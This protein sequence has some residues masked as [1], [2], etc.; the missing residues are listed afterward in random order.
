[1]TG[2]DKEPSDIVG[3]A[4]AAIAEGGLPQLAFGKHASDAL[5]RLIGA[6]TDVPAAYLERF[7]ARIRADTDAQVA[8]TKAVAECGIAETLAA[9]PTLA[10]R[11]AQ[12]WFAGTLRKQLNKDAVAA[13]SARILLEAPLPRDS[14]PPSEEFLDAFTDAAGTA[15]SDE[16]RE[17]FARVLT[18]ELRRPGS[19]SRATLAALTTI[20]ARQAQAFDR[21]LP[22]IDPNAGLLIIDSGFG[23]SVMETGLLFD[24]GLIRDETMFQWLDDED[25]NSIAVLHR[26]HIITISGM[27]KSMMGP[28]IYGGHHLTTTGQELLTALDGGPALEPEQLDVIARGL[29]RELLKNQPTAEVHVGPY[30][31]DGRKV[32]PG[33]LRRLHPVP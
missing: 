24:A 9:D 23:L 22:F 29:T 27:G 16:I 12:G 19:F 6:A 32:V 2:S 17:A 7:S 30:T 20:D 15:T 3:K 10:T 33:T 13:R 5:G 28:P 31:V 21:A 14:L 4:L 8:M 1:M 25:S 18:G 26:S 11:A